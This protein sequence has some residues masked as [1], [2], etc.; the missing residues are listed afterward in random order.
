[1]TAHDSGEAS[2]SLSDAD[3]APATASSLARDS[4]IGLT[5]GFIL[6]T[7]AGLI[8]VGG[9]EFRIP[10]L[11]YLL[12]LEVKSAAGVNLI[13]GLFTVCLSFL[14]RWGQQEQSWPSEDLILG[15]ILVVASLAGSLVGARQAHRLPSRPLKWIVLGYLLIVGAW[16]IVE[17]LTDT[18]VELLI[19]QGTA[20][21]FL[22]SLVGFVIG[23][24]SSSLGVAGGE[25]RIPALMYLFGYDVKVAGTIS[26]LAS[27]P[28]VAAGA[29]TYRRMGHIPNRA[30]LLAFLMGAGSL[31]G[32]L[33]GT[34]LL[35]LVGGQWLKGLL[36]AVLLLA[37]ACLALPEFFRARPASR[38][39]PTHA[40]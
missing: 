6:G 30:L 9:G 24:I 39:G 27:I 29:V 4:F 28:T 16:M 19:P 8:G 13:V 2:L 38:G 12:R 20:R 33:V 3:A 17:A 21:W 10:V 34:A 14:R 23:A 25:M 37:T 31:L 32:V 5:A 7:A 26:L 22:A 40:R 18:E 36:G 1:L 35:P 11:L 15:G